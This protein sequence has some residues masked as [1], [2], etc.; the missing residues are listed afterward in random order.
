MNMNLICCLSHNTYYFK[1][2]KVCTDMY[3]SYMLSHGELKKYCEAFYDSQIDG[4]VLMFARS[5]RVFYTGLAAFRIYRETRDELWIRRA[6]KEMKCMKLWTEKASIWNFQHKLQLMEAEAYYC[7]GNF[8]Q[9][10]ESY[11]QAI[12]SAKAHKYI[13]DEALAYELAGKF[14]LDIGKNASSTE[15]LRLAHEKYWE[16]GAHGKRKQLYGFISTKFADPT[17]ASTGS[18]IT[19]SEQPIIYG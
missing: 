2:N 10:T 13:N 16:W 1:S 11:K 19:M 9:A 8:D 7:Y 5:A 4:S 3:L 14:F 15:Y 12:S 17:T 6:V 18:K